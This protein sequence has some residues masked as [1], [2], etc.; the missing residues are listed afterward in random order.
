MKSKKIAIAIVLDISLVFFIFLSVLGQFYMSGRLKTIEA[1]N[2]MYKEMVK[3]LSGILDDIYASPEV[4]EDIVQEEVKAEL[5]LQIEYVGEFDCAANCCEEYNHICGGT[6]V[7]ASGMPQTAGITAGANFDKLPVG[8]WIYIADVGIR[9][10]QDTGPD[11]PE[12]HIDVAVETH[13]EAL[14]WE[15]YGVHRVWIIGGFDEY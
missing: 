8:T 14:A 1:E 4:E 5:P 12:N 7:T 15:G 2:K 3:S 10:V 13:K 6:G 11:C 9:Q